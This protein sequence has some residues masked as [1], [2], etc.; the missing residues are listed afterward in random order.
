MN[1]KIGIESSKYALFCFVFYFSL[2]VY[3]TKGRLEGKNFNYFFIA[4]FISCTIFLVA[5][6]IYRG[7]KIRSIS[8]IAWFPFVGLLIKQ[9]VNLL[10]FLFFVVFL[11]L[12][13]LP[14]M[15]VSFLKRIANYL[16]CFSVIHAIGVYLQLFFP[17][18]M[19]AVMKYVLSSNGYSAWERIVRFGFKSGFTHQT[20]H[21]A[22]YLIIGILCVTYAKE[23]S[24]K[25]FLGMFAF[26]MIPLFLQGKRTHLI[27]LLVLLMIAYVLMEAPSKRI[28][29]L[30]FGGITLLIVWNFVVPYLPS[31]SNLNGVLG[32]IFTTIYT[33]EERGFMGVV[34]TSGRE[35][36][37]TVS[38]QLFR[39]NPLTGNGWGYFQI[40]LGQNYDRV[41]AVHNVYLQLLCETGILGLVC[42]LL[43][44]MVMLG[45]L[46][47]TRNKISDNIGNAL[48]YKKMWKI[49]FFGEM[50]FS[51]YAFTGNPLYNSDY[52]I[53]YFM[54]IIMNEVIINIIEQT[55]KE[56]INEEIYNYNRY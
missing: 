2:Y 45:R 14:P 41:T 43:G 12:Y 51:I 27:I 9:K 30:F 54:C 26:F 24:K 31:L 3:N 52:L 42:F 5:K 50:F 39:T 37:Y 32:R 35:T 13:I 7:I 56:E 25:K 4:L 17:T 28:Q 40:Y 23:Y 48:L 29:H 33:F 16:F 34:E 46:F 15:D 21:T 11:L 20:S 22:L 53:F 18:A 19:A 44:Q 55:S 10:Y 1:R 49:A 47:K 8:I 6:C 38:L 36:L